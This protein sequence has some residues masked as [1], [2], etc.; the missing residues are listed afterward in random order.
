MYPN[1]DL[2]RDDRENMRWETCLWCGNR[3]FEQS[4]PADCSV[5]R[6]RSLNGLHHFFE[7]LQIFYHHARVDWDQ[8]RGAPVKHPKTNENYEDFKTRPCALWGF[9]ESKR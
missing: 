7:V 8:L 1:N 6:K 9:A 5:N 2:L 4:V 3:D